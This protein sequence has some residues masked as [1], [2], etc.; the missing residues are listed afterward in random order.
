MSTSTPNGTANMNGSFVYAMTLEELQA[1]G[2]ATRTLGSHTVA[3]VLNEEQVYAV[4][5]RCPHMGFP[6]DRGSVRNGILTCHWHHARFDLKT[7]GAFDLWADDTPAFPVEVRDGEIWVDVATQEERVAHARKRLDV[8]L[9]RG[10]S[11]VIGKSAILMEERHL[12][13]ELIQTGVEFGCQYRQ[14]GWGQGLTIL[15][16]MANLLPDLDPEDRSRALFHGL[17]AVA[18]ETSGSPY[19]YRVHALPDE[20]DNLDLLMAWFREFIEVRDFE[21]AERCLTSAIR[22]GAD[23][24]FL[25]DMMASAALDHRYIDIGH[26]MDFTNKA[27]QLL[28]KIGWDK[29]EL[30]LSSLVRGYAMATR[31]EERHAWRHPIDLIVL[32]QETFAALEEALAEGEANQNSWQGDPN[33]VSTILTAEPEPML[34]YLL[35]ALR[36]GLPPAELAVHVCFAAVMRIAQFHTSNEIADW[37]TALHT[38]TFSNAVLQAYKRAPTVNILR[39][40]FDAAMSVYLDRFLNI[41]A[42]RI[43]SGKNGKVEPTDSLQELGSLLDHQYQVNQAGAL[44]AHYVT[45]H[46]DVSPLRSSLGHNLLREDRDFHTIQCIEATFALHD[47]LRGGYQTQ[48]WLNPDVALIAAARYLAAHAPTMRSQGQTYSIALRL[49]RGEN[50]FEG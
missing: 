6:L 23:H 11:L 45:E 16:C 33:L 8:G 40:V 24:V 20:V 21:G 2:I 1:Q 36:Q 49:H 41:P 32:L 42:A 28:D 44:V 13:R 10:L 30:V 29:A 50:I 35:N 4:D 25:M 15:G 48:E 37:D 22:G 27:F 47:E 12:T 39:G 43:P 26:P 34:A 31:M 7:G 46:K 3:L 14:A 17:A 9:E 5:N 18:S 38:F 19:R